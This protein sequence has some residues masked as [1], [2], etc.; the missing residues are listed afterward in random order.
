[1]SIKLQIC[2]GG[3]GTDRDAFLTHNF[4]FNVNHFL[5]LIGVDEQTKNEVISFLLF[6]FI[7]RFT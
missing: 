7:W 6:H 4:I 5:N 1:M 2:W 3:G